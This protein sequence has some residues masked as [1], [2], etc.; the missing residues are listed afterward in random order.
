MYTAVRQ[1]AQML[2][3]TSLKNK[4]NAVTGSRTR[5]PEGDGAP[6]AKSGGGS[7]DGSD[8]GGNR[9][10]SDGEKGPEGQ[11]KNNEDKEGDPVDPITGSFT[12]EQTDFILPDI[13]GEFRLMRRHESLKRH[14]RQLLGDR[15]LSSIGMRLEVRA[16][17]PSC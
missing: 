3:T 7:G 6:P 17:A 4:V 13:V 9:P 5:A 1:G 15:W 2:L 8:G 12:A 14:E 10:K 11:R 16:T